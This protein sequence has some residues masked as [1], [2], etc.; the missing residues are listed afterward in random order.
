V[1]N[2]EKEEIPLLNIERNPL[3]I[4]VSLLVSAISIGF[5]YYLLKDINPFGFLAIIPAGLISF[6]TL[7]Y[8][9]NPF[10]IVFKDKITI[11]QSL[12]HHK[13]HYYIDIKK[14]T[15]H[16]NG[17]LYITFKDDE[18]EVMRLFGIKTSHLMLVKNQ[19]EKHIG[20]PVN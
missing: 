16:K 4:V 7:W 13:D 15:Q 1:R 2:R 11:R 10:A 20:V 12:F 5:A 9:L 18:V 3:V 6:H 19:V 8:M 17:K 14:I